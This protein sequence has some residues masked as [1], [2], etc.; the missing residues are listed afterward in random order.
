MRRTGGWKSPKSGR[1]SPYRRTEFESGN[2]E[3]GWR[4]AQAQTINNFVDE[5]L[6]V[7][8]KANVIVLGDLND[9][10]FSETVE[11]I[12]GVREAADAGPFEADP[13]GSGQTILTDNGPM[14]ATLIDTLQPNER[15]SYVFDGNSQG[16]DQSLVSNALLGRSPLYDV[17]HVNAEFFDQAS[18]HDPSV[19][20]VAFQPRSAS[21]G[22]LPT[23]AP[24]RG[25]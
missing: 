19:M 8:P 9:F 11:I 4:H 6:A 14:M 12:S 20:R 3:D 15:Y 16:L 10:D 21:T 24:V 25:R 5:I 18:D 7:D 23:R 2:P 22:T 17:V 1:S 13:D